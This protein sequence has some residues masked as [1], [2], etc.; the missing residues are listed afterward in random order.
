MLFGSTS[1][2]DY[3][4]YALRRKDLVTLVRQE[5]PE[6]TSGL[7]V[8]CAGFENDRTAF[9]QDSSFYYLTGIEEPGVVLTVDFHGKSTFYTPQCKAN[10]SAWVHSAIPLIQ[11]N[12]KTLLIDHFKAAGN[13]TAGYQLSSFSDLEGFSNVLAAMKSVIAAGGSIFTL[14]PNGA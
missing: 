7:I 5:H 11:E 9:R 3:S 12:G 14:L 6:V 13:P 2:H 8:I 4:V 10:R 1:L